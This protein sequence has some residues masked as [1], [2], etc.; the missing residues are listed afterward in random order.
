MTNGDLMVNHW[1]NLNCILNGICHH[2]SGTF[3]LAEMDVQSPLTEN[4]LVV[5]ISIQF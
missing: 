2:S 5:I 4:I 1:E 3:Y